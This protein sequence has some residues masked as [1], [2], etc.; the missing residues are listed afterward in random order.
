MAAT[1]DATKKAEVPETFSTSFLF[2][3]LWDYGP[4]PFVRLTNVNNGQA[5]HLYCNHDSNIPDDFISYYNRANQ[6]VAVFEFPSE[7]ICREFFDCAA[8]YSEGKELKIEVNRQTKKII[9]IE[10]PEGCKKDLW[11]SLEQNADG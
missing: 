9:K 11:S 10:L 6:P 7:K 2:K 5:S 4:T 3:D 1:E 8:Y